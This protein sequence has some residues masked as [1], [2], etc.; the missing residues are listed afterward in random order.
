MS[1]KISVTFNTSTQDGPR[2]GSHPEKPPSA[3]CMEMMKSTASE[4]L[5]SDSA[6][7]VGLFAQSP[8]SSAQAGGEHCGAPKLAL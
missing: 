1:E 6:S 5:C 2:V 4:S 7:G 3:F 8:F